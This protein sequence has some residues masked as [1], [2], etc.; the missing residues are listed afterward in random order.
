MTEDNSSSPTLADVPAELVA[1]FV[2]FVAGTCPAYNGIIHGD[3]F[4]PD[5]TCTKGL[6]KALLPLLLVNRAFFHAGAM[7][8]WSHLGENSYVEEL[9]GHPTKGKSLLGALTTSPRSS[10]YGS[11]VRSL[12]VQMPPFKM[13][14]SS[15]LETVLQSLEA[16][17]G[18]L[19]NLAKL[20]LNY[21]ASGLDWSL[22]DA[23]LEAAAGCPLRVLDLRRV[24]IDDQIFLAG[25]K[26][27]NLSSL[28][29]GTDCVER[30]F[31]KMLASA[32]P[33]GVRKLSLTKKAAPA[34]TEDLESLLGRIK[35]LEA[36]ELSITDGLAQPEPALVKRCTANL[37]ELSL[38]ITGLWR[39]QDVTIGWLENVE[40]TSLTS[41]E[42]VSH[43]WDEGG[44]V[45]SRLLA[46]NPRLESIQLAHCPLDELDAGVLFANCP[47]GLRE[48]SL[49]GCDVGEQLPAILSRTPRLVTLSFTS[50]TLPPNGALGEGMLDAICALGSL[51]KLDLALTHFLVTKDDLALALR[52][53]P[54]LEILGL[55]FEPLK[56]NRKWADNVRKWNPK[57]RI[58]NTP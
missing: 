39:S 7:K 50:D 40:S 52:K 31:P 27:W 5:C 54:R 28:T 13:L 33:A 29:V 23:I 25:L 4:A 15:N 9:F 45:F 14:K 19:P 41:L 58:V 1:R 6:R 21:D 26:R 11:C 22:T 36:L 44:A 43:P 53:M 51:R 30:R 56:I 37:Q 3:A 47:A 35:H 42:L 18:R 34:A 16:I 46:C 55:P 32:I 20:V 2:D 8:I 24:N 57:I 48:L 49:M 10:F 38:S 17:V 12:F